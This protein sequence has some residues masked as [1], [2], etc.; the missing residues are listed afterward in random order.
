VLSTTAEILDHNSL[1]SR[2][3]FEPVACAGCRK[4]CIKNDFSQKN[5]VV[6]TLPGDYRSQ[7]EVTLSLRDQLVLLTNSLLLPLI[8][9]IAGGS[10]S[11]YMQLGE[12]GTVAGAIVGL[13]AGVAMCKSQSYSRLNIKEVRI[14]E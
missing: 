14:N 7:I 12:V 6:M 5:M 2:I 1:K 8:G 13:S 9:F 11:D 10:I 3:Q 4:G